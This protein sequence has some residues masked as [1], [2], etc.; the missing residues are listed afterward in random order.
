MKQIKT[1]IALFLMVGALAPVISVSFFDSEHKVIL[2]PIAILSAF[3]G[4]GLMFG[5]T[6]FRTRPKHIGNFDK[7]NIKPDINQTWMVFFI[8]LVINLFFANLCGN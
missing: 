7:D 4:T 6:N 3:I 2:A 8:T 1:I 5:F